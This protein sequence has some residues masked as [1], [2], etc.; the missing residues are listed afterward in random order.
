MTR[1]LRV[2]IEFFIVL[3]L[4]GEPF[5]EL[6]VFRIERRH[7]PN[8]IINEIRLIK[9]R[10]DAEHASTE[11]AALSPLVSGLRRGCFRLSVLPSF[12]EEDLPEL[13]QPVRVNESVLT[14]IKSLLP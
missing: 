1:Q 13:S 7:N 4:F 3:V 8:V 12:N 5:L 9:F 14:R 10:S 2:V 11:P 6:D